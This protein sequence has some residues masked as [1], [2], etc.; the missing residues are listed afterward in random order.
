MAYFR[1]RKLLDGARDAPCMSCGIEDGTVVACHANSY[2]LGKG[3]H[4]K[5]AD[6]LVA[7]CCYACHT[8]IDSSTL[9]REEKDALWTEAFIR[10]V[11]YMFEAGIVK[12]K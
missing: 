8:K 5:V 10:T 12:V 9:D 4:L 1:S 7:Y 6:Y 11:A 3:G 2:A